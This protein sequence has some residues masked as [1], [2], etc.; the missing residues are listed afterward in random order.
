VHIL[1]PKPWPT[2]REVRIF[3]RASVRVTG[4]V[5]IGRDVRQHRR[6]LALAL[7]A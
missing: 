7:A 1:A 5:L 3:G 4:L 2:R 6:N